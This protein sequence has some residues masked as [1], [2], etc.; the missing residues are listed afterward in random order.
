MRSFTP[1][2][3]LTL[4]FP[5]LAIWWPSP[6]KQP[7]AS[8]A[9]YDWVALGPSGAR[10]VPSLKALNP[11]LI[12]L[13][14]TDA[15]QVAY[16]PS[17]DAPAGANAELEA[18]PTAWLLTQVGATLTADVGT[19]DTTLRVDRVAVS[20]GGHTYNLF[21]PG[22]TVVVGDE[23]AYVQA[24]DGA[25]DTLT[26]R[27]GCV[28]PAEAHTSGTRVAAAIAFWPGTLLCDA[29]TDCPAVTVDPTVG[30]ET[31]D[32]YNA[33]VAAGLLSD[34]VWDGILV[35]D[36]HS[37]VSWMVGDSTA[38]T[39]DPD[40]SNTL[41]IDYSGFDAASGTGVRLYEATLRSL[42]GD[43]RLIYSNSD[44]DYDLLNGGNFEAFPPPMIRLHGVQRSSAPSLAGATSSGWQ[45][46]CSPT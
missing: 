10:F 8:I 31:W 2:Q 24:V 36:A 27:R 30:P 38:R 22:D 13:T 45:V 25:E 41:T 35:D 1:G 6:S 43:D 29:S 16:N 34:D 18:I 20:S 42:V 3:P 39:I 4:P 40:R 46:A 37:T 7:L 5:R 28:K 26:V 15:C 9:R 23:L 17:P 14:S 44:P 11:N 12:A 33:R 21:Q 32:Q 19:A